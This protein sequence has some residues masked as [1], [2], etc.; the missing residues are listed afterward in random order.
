MASRFL[1]FKKSG[2]K[3]LYEFVPEADK[4]SCLCLLNVGGLLTINNKLIVSGANVSDF[5]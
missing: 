2:A 4:F 1:N 5:N 3:A